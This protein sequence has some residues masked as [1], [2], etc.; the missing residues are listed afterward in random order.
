MESSCKKKDEVKR[1]HWKG[2]QRNDLGKRRSKS[3]K[4]FKRVSKIKESEQNAQKQCPSEQQQGGDF[5]DHRKSRVAHIF[6]FLKKN[7]KA[8]TFSR[9]I[10]KGCAFF[11]RKKNHRPHTILQNESQGIN[12][13]K[14][15]KKHWA[16]SFFTA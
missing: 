1:S 6:F 3:T 12:T 4:S 2:F 5:F 10:I 13:S 15:S 16:Q 9:Q 11:F 14:S 8:H 7:H